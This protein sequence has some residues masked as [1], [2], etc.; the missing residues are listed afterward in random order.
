MS[1]KANQVAEIRQLLHGALIRLGNPENTSDLESCA[2]RIADAGG[3]LRE[4][5]PMQRPDVDQLGRYEAVDMSLIGRDEPS[6]RGYV[7]PKK[8]SESALP[9]CLV[10]PRNVYGVEKIY[11]ANEVAER[12]ARLA[13]QK[14]LDQKQL[15]EIR[16]LGFAVE[17][18]QVELR[19][20]A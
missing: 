13:G 11:P 10:E 2:W 3:L 7:I 9:V 6:G 19:R 8:V 17:A 1:E 15:A 5:L 12:F 16:A 20:A 4:I 14:T 18:K